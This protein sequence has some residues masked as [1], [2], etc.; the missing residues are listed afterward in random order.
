MQ[1]MFG[2]IPEALTNSVKI[3]EMVDIKIETG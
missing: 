2:F 1:T 3:A